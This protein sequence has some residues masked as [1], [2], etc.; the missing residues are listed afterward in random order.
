MKEI[1]IYGITKRKSQ[2]IDPY[3]KTFSFF[4]CDDIQFMPI[5]GEEL[6][7]IERIDLPIHHVC[8]RVLENKD[9]FFCVEPELLEI[10]E[11]PF[12]IQ[13]NESIKECENLKLALNQKRNDLTE[14]KMEISELLDRIDRFAKLPVWKRI[15]FVIRNS[16]SLLVNK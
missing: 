5:K 7:F 16:Q 2:I 14:L 10:L 11:A 13:L 9:I 8:Q 4:K 3:Q 1:T 15:W 6:I 12:K